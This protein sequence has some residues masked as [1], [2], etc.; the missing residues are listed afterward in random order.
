MNT[1]LDVGHLFSTE[2]PSFVA[3]PRV[4]ATVIER[5]EPIITDASDND[6]ADF[7]HMIMI[8]IFASSGRPE[9]TLP[10]RH[11]SLYA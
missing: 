3:W 7:A 8:A 6:H 11:L 9:E 4:A 10:Y 5:R 1:I 2:D